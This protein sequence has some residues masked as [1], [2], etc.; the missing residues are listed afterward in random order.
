MKKI[1]LTLPALFCL[2][3]QKGLYEPCRR[4]TDRRHYYWPG[5]GYLCDNTS[6]IVSG[7]FQFTANTRYGNEA[8]TLTE[9][10]FDLQ[11]Q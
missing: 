6:G 8:I 2:P 4:N 3:R 1:P 11:L 10:C 5:C 7:T 9:D